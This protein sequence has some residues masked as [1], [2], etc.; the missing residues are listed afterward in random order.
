LAARL[1]VFVGS[2]TLEA[3]AAVCNADNRLPFDVT[4]GVAA[5]VDQSLLRQGEGTD[6]EA[7]F[8]MLETVR[9]YALERL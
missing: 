1:G 9:E 2:S 5:L 7:R 8:F 3:V 4:D 6:G